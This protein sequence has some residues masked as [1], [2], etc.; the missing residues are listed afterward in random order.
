MKKKKRKSKYSLCYCGLDEYSKNDILSE[1]T[2]GQY[3]TKNRGYVS[4]ES[5]SLK[6]LYHQSPGIV[7]KLSKHQK[8][9][10]IFE[11]FIDLEDPLTPL[12]ARVNFGSDLHEDGNNSGSSILVPLV[13]QDSIFS[14]KDSD[15]EEFD[16]EQNEKAGI[17]QRKYR[18]KM[19][20][21]KEQEEE[22][23]KATLI[24]RQYRIKLQKRKEKEE[25]NEKATLIQRKYREKLERKK[26]KEEEEENEK[27]TVIQQ[28]YRAKKKKQALLEE[29]HRQGN[30]KFPKYL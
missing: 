25:E 22:N 29:K 8:E 16:E 12:G 5:S 6:G 10:G 15:K 4:D 19:Q 28:M 18:E 7:E 3:Q 20:K 24:Q 1:S 30:L 26:A 9:E 27:A 21:R 13:D 23:D 2:D 17:I 14:H 11:S